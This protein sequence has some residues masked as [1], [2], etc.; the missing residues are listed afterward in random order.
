MP[1]THVVPFRCNKGYTLHTH[2]VKVFLNLHF[3]LLTL[4]FETLEKEPCKLKSD[5]V[6][7]GHMRV[8]KYVI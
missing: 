4:F 7:N 1:V 6:L 8:P 3:T 5:I 2:G